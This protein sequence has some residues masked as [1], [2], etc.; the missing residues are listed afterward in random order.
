M[1]RVEAQPVGGM[2]RVMAVGLQ[3]VGVAPGGLGRSCGC[4]GDTPAAPVAVVVL[5]GRLLVM[6]GLARERGSGV[7]AGIAQGPAVRG[8]PLAPDRLRGQGGLGVLGGLAGDREAAGR[9]KGVPIGSTVAGQGLAR[10]GLG[11]LGRGAGGWQWWWGVG[12]AGGGQGWCLVLPH[13]VG[14]GQVATQGLPHHPWGAGGGH[15]VVEGAQ[16]RRGRQVGGDVGEG[17]G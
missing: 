5:L 6:G 4:W 14:R 15:C 2:R 3:A 16:G 9:G 8:W 11:V 7:G 12:V 1:R 13:A 10:R 17:R